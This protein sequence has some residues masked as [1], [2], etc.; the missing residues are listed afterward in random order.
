MPELG[1]DLERLA[2]IPSIAFPGYPT[3]PV[4]DAHDLI[5]ELLRAAGVRTIDKPCRSHSWSGRPRATRRWRCP[6][7]VPR[8]DFAWVDRSLVITAW[9]ASSGWINL[10]TPTSAVIMGGLA[11]REGSLRQVRAVRGPAARDPIRRHMRV[12]CARRRTRLMRTASSRVTTSRNA[13]SADPS[14]ADGAEV[15]DLNGR[16]RYRRKDQQSATPRQATASAEAKVGSSTH[17]YA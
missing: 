16:A 4:R 7:L 13:P 17:R 10:I 9:N 12:P 3:E 6:I 5:V 15:V 2:R 14:L 11:P 1:T 8:G